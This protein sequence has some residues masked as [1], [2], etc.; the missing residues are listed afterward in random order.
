MTTRGIAGLHRTRPGLTEDEAF[1]LVLRIATSCSEIEVKEI[2]AA[3]AAG[4]VGAAI[5]G[6]RT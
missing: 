1:D 3:L 5:R 6:S 2:A 4:G